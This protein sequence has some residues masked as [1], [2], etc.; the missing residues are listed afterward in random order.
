MLFAMTTPALPFMGI[1]RANPDFFVEVSL[2]VLGN[3]YV[4]GK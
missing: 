4:E 3:T 1:S 2:E